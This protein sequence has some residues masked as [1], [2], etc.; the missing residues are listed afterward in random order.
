MHGPLEP[1][2]MILFGNRAFAHEISVGIKRRSYW[3]REN[4]KSRKSVLM[5][6]H[7]RIYRNP[8]KKVI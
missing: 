8:E 5:E 1:Q 6:R 7:K 2:N 3:I 4:P